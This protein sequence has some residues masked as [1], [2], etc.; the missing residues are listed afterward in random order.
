MS[1]VAAVAPRAAP[2]PFAPEPRDGSG[3]ASVSDRGSLSIP[4][5]TAPHALVG[6]LMDGED[7]GQGPTPCSVPALLSVQNQR[8]GGRCP[9]ARAV[10]DTWPLCNGRDQAAAT[11]T[12]NINQ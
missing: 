5:L 6:W 2:G 10:E 9:Q 7:Q 11:E 3:S 12:R 1:A 8:E 4:G